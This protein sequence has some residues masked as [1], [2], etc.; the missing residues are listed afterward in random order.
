MTEIENRWGR[1][2]F[3]KQMREL[4]HAGS[5]AGSVMALSLSTRQRIYAFI[6]R[7]GSFKRGTWNGCVMNAASGEANVTSISAAAHYF[8]EPYHTISDFIGQWD[9]TP[10]DSV[11]ANRTLEKILLEVGLTT[12]SPEYK[13]QE[14]NKVKVFRV[15]LFTSAETKAVEELRAEI[16]AGA[17]DADL[18]EFQELVGV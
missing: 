13:P 12:E 14:E 8:Q 9:A 7:G 10:G 2:G 3:E 11:S 17:F 18:A 5:L 15:R 16:E 1:P 6:Q 4:H